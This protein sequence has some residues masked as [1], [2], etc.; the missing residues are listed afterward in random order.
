MAKELETRRVLYDSAVDLRIPSITRPTDGV[1]QSS[2]YMCVITHHLQSTEPLDALPA[3]S[4]SNRSIYLQPGI[5]LP[6]ARLA[7][8][9]PL[10]HYLAG[11]FWVYGL[12]NDE[13]AIS[14]QGPWLHQLR[15]RHAGIEGSSSTRYVDVGERKKE[16]FTPND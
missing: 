3:F 14:E 8:C 2:Q 1:L 16:S 11:V 5:G 12:H 15:E 10:R 9:A 6:A 13:D 4:L 7:R